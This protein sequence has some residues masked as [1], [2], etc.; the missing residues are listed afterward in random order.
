M[1]EEVE[2]RC[3]YPLQI[4]EEQ[5]ER[6]L[7]PRKNTQ[8]APEDQKE[9][10]LRILGRQIRDRRLLADHQLQFGNQ[11]HDELP[12]LTQRLAQPVPPA[13]E[14]R[15]T[16]DQQRTDKALKGLAQGGVWDVALV[17]V[18]LP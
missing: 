6:M 16:L 7:F 11:V 12:I 10:M 13:A 2:R 15:V 4:V 1:L 3:V 17:L 9:T 14:L 8:E 5:C 18:E